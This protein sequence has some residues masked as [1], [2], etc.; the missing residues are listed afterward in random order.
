MAASRTVAIHQPN[1][2]PWAGYFHKIAHC[3]IFVYLDSVQFPRGQSFGARNRIKTPNG[4]AFLTIPVS[5]PKS[6]DGKAPYTKVG[7][8]DARWKEKHAKTVAQSYRRA[9][10]FDEVYALYEQELEPDRPFVELTIGLI[11]AFCG[12]LAIETERVRLSDTV[13]SAH[14][15]TDLI[16]DICQALGADAYLSGTG[17]GKDYNDEQLLREHGVELRYDEFSP[18]V[19]PQLWGDFEPGL[20]VLDLLFNCGRAG[21]DL[22]A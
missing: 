10:H 22:V 4:A 14:Q 2:L 1:Y 18:P 8:A 11:E 17:G 3:D 12:Y 19:Y 6:H 7:F 20:S 9:P 16:V 5:V 15:K 21:R 13:E